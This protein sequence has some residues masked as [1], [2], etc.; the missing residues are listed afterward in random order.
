MGDMAT[1]EAGETEVG[2]DGFASVVGVGAGAL[3]DGVTEGE[4]GAEEVGGVEAGVAVAVGVGVGGVDDASDSA[5]MA[6]GEATATEDDDGGV[7]V[8]VGGEAGSGEGGHSGASEGDGASVVGEAAG[9]SAEAVGPAAISALASGD[10]G[11]SQ[12]GSAGCEG[13]SPLFSSTPGEYASFGVGGGDEDFVGA[14][15]D[16]VAA[17]AVDR[18]AVGAAVEVVDLALLVAEAGGVAAVGA[19]FVVVVV[20]GEW[21]GVST[22]VIRREGR[23]WLGGSLASSAAMKSP[24]APHTQRRSVAPLGYGYSTCRAPGSGQPRT[25]QAREPELFWTP[26]P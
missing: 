16:A 1:S 6:L 19:V 25:S 24:W 11:P 21:H 3:A 2:A 4:L 18:A 23:T 15:P 17:P 7:A 26:G 13:S 10:D 12:S 8:V 14:G 5:W 22:R 9:A 20:V